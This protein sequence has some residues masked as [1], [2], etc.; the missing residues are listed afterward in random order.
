MD[1]ILNDRFMVKLLIRPEGLLL[2]MSDFI[3][4]LAADFPYQLINPKIT[5]LLFYSSL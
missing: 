5:E 1:E 4:S 3:F 2:E